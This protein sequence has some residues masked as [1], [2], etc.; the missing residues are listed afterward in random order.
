MRAYSEE[1]E[2]RHEDANRGGKVGS[3]GDLRRNTKHDRI[4]AKSLTLRVVTPLI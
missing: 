1:W 4:L 2:V 3:A